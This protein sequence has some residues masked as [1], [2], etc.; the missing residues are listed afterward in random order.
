M[1]RLSKEVG[2]GRSSRSCSAGCGVPRLYWFF[3]L[4][5]CVVLVWPS[6]V[7]AALGGL[8]AMQL[9]PTPGLKMMPVTPPLDPM[10]GRD[11]C[12]GVMMAS[13]KPEAGRQVQEIVLAVWDG[14]GSHPTVSGV[15]SSFKLFDKL[16][17]PIQAGDPTNTLLAWFNDDTKFQRF[18]SPNDQWSF[19]RVPVQSTW[20]KG[21]DDYLLKSMNNVFMV[22]FV[23]AGGNPDAPEW[24]KGYRSYAPGAGIQLH[25]RRQ[26]ESEWQELTSTK[27]VFC[28]GDSVEL[29]ASFGEV[30]PQGKW[31]P[32]PSDEF[33]YVWDHMSQPLNPPAGYSLTG[34]WQKVEAD[35]AGRLITVSREKFCDMNPSISVTVGAIAKPQLSLKPA[36]VGCASVGVEDQVAVEVSS[37]DLPQVNTLEWRL[38]QQN[39]QVGQSTHVATETGPFTSPHTY[40]YNIKFEEVGGVQPSAATRELMDSVVLVARGQECQVRTKVPLRVLRKPDAPDLQVLQDGTALVPDGTQTYNVCDPAVVKLSSGVSNTVFLPRWTIGVGGSEET[41]EVF[42]IDDFRASLFGTTVSKEYALKFQVGVDLGVPS[43]VAEQSAKLVVHPNTRPVVSLGY[44]PVTKCAPS[45]FTAKDDDASGVPVAKRTW[46]LLTWNGT[47]YVAENKGS[48]ATYEESNFSVSS[49]DV[50]HLPKVRLTTETAKG[51]KATNETVVEVKPLAAVGHVELL[52]QGNKEC[53][54]VQFT[55][56]ASGLTLAQNCRV[57]LRAPGKKDQLLTNMP[58]TAGQSEVT[59][60]PFEVPNVLPTPVEYDVVVITEPQDLYSCSSEGSAKL[61]V[62]PQV[63]AGLSVQKP[64]VCADKDGHAKVRVSDLSVTKPGATV[65]WYAGAAPITPLNPGA[66]PLEFQLENASLTDPAV[67]ALKQE[68]V[69]GGC[70][71]SQEASVTV[72]PGLR[73][74]IAMS[75]RNGKG[76]YEPY[77]AGDKLCAPD[78]MT[79]RVEGADN[80]S[81]EALAAGRTGTGTELR[82]V[83][84]VNPDEADKKYTVRVVSTNR[85]SCSESA[86]VELVVHQEVGAKFSLEPLSTCN[87]IR[88][89]RVYEPVGKADDTWTGLGTPAGKPEE[90]V[91]DAPGDHEVKLVRKATT[92]CTAEHTEH[93]VVPDVLKVSIEATPVPGK[94]LCGGQGVEFKNVSTGHLGRFCWDFGDGSPLY[95]QSADQIANGVKHTYLNVSGVKKEYTVKLKAEVDAGCGEGVATE[96]SLVMTVYPTGSMGQSMQ[97]KENCNP[98]KLEVRTACDTYNHFTWSVVDQA[99]TVVSTVTMDGTGVQAKELTLENNSTAAW[100]VYTLKLVGSRDWKSPDV[101]C[102]SP[103]VTLDEVKIPPHIDQKIEPDKKAI[104]SGDEVIFT[105]ATAGSNVVHDYYFDYLG[106]KRDVLSNQAMGT[107]VTH[108]FVNDGSVDKTYQVV[109]S[110]KMESGVPGC[111]QQKKVV[112]IVVHAAVRAGFTAKKRDDC[113][114]PTQVVLRFNGQLASPASAAVTSY[115]WDFT[116]FQAPGGGLVGTIKRTDGT[117]FEQSFFNPEAEAMATHDIIFTLEQSYPDGVTCKDQATDKLELYPTLKAMFKATPMEG[118]SPLT[119]EFTNQST[120]AGKGELQYAWDFKNGSTSVSRDPGSS[121]FVNQGTVGVK[122]ATTLQVS[123]GMCVDTHTEEVQVGPAPRAEFALNP[124]LAVC[125]PAE[126]EVLNASEFAT[127]YTWTLSPAADPIPPTHDL[128]PFKIKLDNTTGAD[129]EYTVKLVAS[130]GP[131]G[132]TASKEV[133][134]TVHP[135]ISADFSMSVVE[136]CNPLSVQFTNKST[137]QDRFQWSFF[138]QEESPTHIFQHTDREHSQDF[139][140]WLEVSNTRTGCTSRKEEKVTVYPYLNAS[141]DTKSPLQGCSPLKVKVTNSGIS[142]AYAYYWEPGGTHPATTEQDPGTFEYTNTT[143]GAVQKFTLSLKVIDKDHKQCESAPFVREIEVWPNVKADFTLPAAGCSPLTLEFVNQTVDPSGECRYAWQVGDG[144]SGERNYKTTLTNPSYDDV[145]KCPVVLEVTTKQGCSDKLEKVLEVYPTPRAQFNMANENAGCAPFEVVLTNTTLGKGATYTIDF[146]DGTPPEVRTVLGEVK[147]SY[148][149]ADTKPKGC[150]LRLVAENVHGCKSEATMPLTVYPMVKAQFDIGKQAAACSPFELELVNTTLNEQGSTW[151]W[152]F[153]GLDSNTSRSPRYIF[154]NTTTEDKTY[155]IKLVA[156]TANGCESETHK[157]ITVWPTPQANFEVTPPLSVF[158]DP[159]VVVS[160]VD[161][162]EP[163]AAGWSYLWDFNDANTSTEH[164][165]KEHTFT[166]WASATNGYQYQVR[167]VVEAPHGCKDTAELPVWV[168]APE[169]TTRFR[170]PKNWGCAPF[171]AYFYN[172]TQYADEYLWRFGDGD[173]ATEREVMHVYEKPGYYQVT[174]TARGEGGTQT[175]Y[176]VV[177][178]KE[179]PVADFS[180]SPEMPVMLPDARVRFVNQSQKGDKYRWDFGDGSVG[181][182]ESPVHIYTQTGEYDVV[183]EVA[184][185]EGCKAEKRLKSAVVVLPGGYLL[186]PTAFSPRAGGASG[187]WYRPEDYAD[188]SIFRPKFFGVQQYHLTVYDRLGNVLFQTDDIKQ[189]WDGY[190]GGRLCQ[191]GVY[192]YR[193]V[194]HYKSGVQFDV[195]GNFTLIRQ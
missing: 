115:Q 138:D 72:N 180:V 195:R 82:D 128:Q 50:L 14:A 177:E 74:V 53:T 163:T 152:T 80:A 194:G 143:P 2:R 92:G 96:N 42:D 46:E 8:R 111:M 20:F 193:A 13:I 21:S 31:R 75:K 108:K 166:Q 162:T 181:D 55:V 89:K 127:E 56:K 100:A 120:G 73:P 188:Y 118:C 4:F 129:Q 175:F 28:S 148:E 110:S 169:P 95:Y 16:G 136:G 77:T 185:L 97:V 32:T 182:T 35:Q 5:V 66:N 44:D 142:P 99:G 6:R 51:C 153:N 135:H 52:Y 179:N 88:V 126:I 3:L 147:H 190:V 59:T 86:E 122:Y 12:A 150:E 141:F 171:N 98:M 160:I 78:T 114:N 34:A 174:L 145:W 43:C 116:G 1:R 69:L 40:T 134:V 93:V 123:R 178:V 109:V 87:P 39:Q 124:S 151:L 170:M 112:D 41:R 84:L 17:Q 24:A 168:L 184:S 27:L 105:D 139:P 22:G 159:G 113:H 189:G 161:R 158:K 121:V 61:V 183:L 18:S 68:V 9:P 167:L 119:V 85:F 26:D 62:Q 140:V 30:D 23:Y 33:H 49:Y 58:L 149:N 104:C 133:K 91:F 37:F 36:K 11:G 45:H 165:V 130:N 94:V 60:P 137:G 154:T 57:V 81:W 155:D 64:T 117:D 54:P 25:Y 76:A 29:D 101:T 15:G 157:E 70:T 7:G 164:D 63:A 10:P 156:K 65:T 106:N 173:S 107:L 19:T 48:A 191:F 172:E 186:Y 71:V 103:E 79:F 67:V 47:D 144:K 132:C 131:G 90:F 102:T 146:G 125:A 83:I 192:A 176:R 38:V 187:G